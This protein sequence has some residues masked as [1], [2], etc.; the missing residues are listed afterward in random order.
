[1]ANGRKDFVIAW[2]MRILVGTI[3]PIGYWVWET[4][5]SLVLFH[6][7]LEQSRQSHRDDLAAFRS[8]IAELTTTYHQHLEEHRRQAKREDD[9]L[10]DRN[11][12]IVNAITELRD[13]IHLAETELARL[14]A[15]Q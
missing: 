3:P 11:Q 9:K 4:Q 5:T 15:R 10:R 1:M 2:I 6:E 7:R 14:G 12:F 13:K 8:E